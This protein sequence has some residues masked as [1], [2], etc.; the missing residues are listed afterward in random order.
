MDKACFEV[1]GCFTGSSLRVV[2]AFFM[3]FDKVRG[4]DRV[5]TVALVDEAVVP[6]PLSSGC[7][8][9]SL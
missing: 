8:F 9:H 7:S 3:E 5:A 4:G 2:G 6:L 1:E